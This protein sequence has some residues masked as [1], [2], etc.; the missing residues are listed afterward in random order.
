NAPTIA[1]IHFSR[2]GNPI[3]FTD[4]QL[5]YMQRVLKA[6]AQLWSMMCDESNPFPMPHDGYLKLYQL[7]RPDLSKHY[8][9]ILVD[10]AQDTVPV[11]AE[12]VLQSGLSVI[13][14]GDEAQAIYAWRGAVDFLQ[15]PAF[16]RADRMYLTQSFRFGPN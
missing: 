15:N 12:I 5:T 7:S 8:D 16:D 9:M 14:V 13:L 10:E 1:P 6:A 4:A 11:V 3:N 2:E